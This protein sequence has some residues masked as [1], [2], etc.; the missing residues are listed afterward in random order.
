[1]ERRYNMIFPVELRHM[2]TGNIR[3][4]TARLA[5]PVEYSLPIGDQIISL[6][7]KIGREIT[8]KHT[9]KINCIACNRAIKKSFNQGYCFPCSQSL[10]ECDICIVRPERCHFDEGTCRDPHWAQSHCFQPH[11]IYLSVAS[12]VKVGITRESQ[13]PTRFIDQGATQALP[14]IK[15]KSRYLSGLIEVIFSKNTSDKTNWR[16]MLQADNT[17]PQD[18]FLSTCEEL[19][20]KARPE[21]EKLSEKFGHDAI[22]LLDNRE[23]I[24]ISYPIDTYL[25]KISSFNFDKTP[26]VSGILQGIKGQ[27]LVLDKGVLNIRKFSG[28]EL[29][30]SE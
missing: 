17:I 19:L 12:G 26:E 9:G 15:V 4:M 8:L 23:I 16:K 21:I 29:D 28:Y 13:V 6:N 24:S 27:Y 10:A 18:E 7:N 20:G 11:F 5:G 3:K 30:I 25:S 1:M 14:I 22:E 2:T